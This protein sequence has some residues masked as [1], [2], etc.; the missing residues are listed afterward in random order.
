MI[1]IRTQGSKNVMSVI[2]IY[3]DEM[4]FVWSI[5]FI[6]AK[7]E[8]HGVKLRS[9][10]TDDHCVKL[11]SETEIYKVSL[12]CYY[13]QYKVYGWILSFAFSRHSSSWNFFGWE[14]VLLQLIFV[15]YFFKFWSRLSSTEQSYEKLRNLAI[16]HGL[17]DTYDEESR[18]FHIFNEERK[19]SQ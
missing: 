8:D 2:K 10:K 16:K 5:R 14:F 15:Y 4:Y 17:G 6:I 13:W 11:R 7:T 19:T 18:Q 12:Q 9:A 3:I 1:T